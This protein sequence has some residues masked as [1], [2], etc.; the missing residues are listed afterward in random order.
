[1]ITIEHGRKGVPALNYYTRLLGRFVMANDLA[2]FQAEA[3]ARGYT[4]NLAVEAGSAPAAIAGELRVVEY[5]TFDSGTDPGDDVTMYLI[6]SRSGP[7]GY[8]ILSDS[9]HADPRKAAFIDALLEM[10]RLD[11]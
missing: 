11:R 5:V 10:P 1:L 2:G 8:L 7:Q 6:E 4:R 9:F 3:I